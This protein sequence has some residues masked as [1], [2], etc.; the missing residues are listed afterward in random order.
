[1]REIRV[2]NLDNE[3]KN[4]LRTVYTFGK[5]VSWIDIAQMGGPNGDK[6]RADFM[7]R[8]EE[9]HFKGLIDKTSS[10]ELGD[11]YTLTSFGNNIAEYY[12]KMDEKRMEDK[13]SEGHKVRN[14][15]GRLRQIFKTSM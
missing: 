12:S 13:L 6:I 3:Q 5:P 7:D 8:L 2:V 1:M 15:I 4:A 10:P 9:L 14:L 11:I